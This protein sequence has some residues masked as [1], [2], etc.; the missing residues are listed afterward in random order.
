MICGGQLSKVMVHLRQ[1]LALIFFYTQSRPRILWS[2]NYLGILGERRSGKEYLKTVRP[3]Y[4]GSH[5]E[6]WK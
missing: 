2:G 6:H 3:Q 4:L 5:K 1:V